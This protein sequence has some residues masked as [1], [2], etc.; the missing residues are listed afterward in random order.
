MTNLTLLL[1]SIHNA[2]IWHQSLLGLLPQ[3]AV[4][5]ICPSADRHM[6]L[7][8]PYLRVLWIRYM[9]YHRDFRM[10]RCRHC[11]KGRCMGDQNF[12]RRGLL[13]LHRHDHKSLRPE[14]R[15]GDNAA[16]GSNHHEKSPRSSHLEGNA[17]SHLPEFEQRQQC[18][19]SSNQSH[20]SFGLC[21]RLQL[22]HQKTRP[23]NFEQKHYLE[24]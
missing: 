5:L 22:L 19:R 21:W 4:Q 20:P 12:R 11:R 9:P 3:S 23:R 16:A 17:D 14:N 24:H 7:E 13:A 2:G 15:A 10:S 6:N 1:S 8:D 18:Y